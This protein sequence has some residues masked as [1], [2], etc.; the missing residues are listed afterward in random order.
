MPIIHINEICEI[1]LNLI[2][3]VMPHAVSQEMDKGRTTRIKDRRRYH[4]GTCA[5][6][7]LRFPVFVQTV[8]L[9]ER[10]KEG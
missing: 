9:W 4:A 2:L 8:K 3:L 6:S 7:A 1:C 10:F 5:D